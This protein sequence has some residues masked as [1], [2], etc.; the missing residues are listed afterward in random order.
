[1]QKG[2]EY[3]QHLGKEDHK[4]IAHRE[5]VRKGLLAQPGKG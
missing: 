5:H 3:L 1:M 4:R 2:G